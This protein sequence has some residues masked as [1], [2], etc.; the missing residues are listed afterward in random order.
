MSI[1][2][3]ELKE[4]HIVLLRSFKWCEMDESMVIKTDS[5]DNPLSGYDYHDVVGAMIFGLPDNYV[6]IEDE[7]IPFT[8]QQ[9]EEILTEASA[10]GLRWEVQSTA[11][12]IM[13]ENP[14]LDKVE[15][16]QQAFSEWVK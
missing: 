12:Q 5:E 11:E 15:A 3:F 2:K 10:F 8:E 9:I 6:A 16:Y 7:C 14:N 13:D 4:E 1:L